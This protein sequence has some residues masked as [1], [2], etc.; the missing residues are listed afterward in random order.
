MEKNMKI[1]IDTDWFEMIQDLAPEK[2]TE[3]L[4]AILNYPNTESETRI[5]KN[6]IKPQLEKGRIAY[7]NKINNLKQ[8]KK[9]PAETGVTK[10]SKEKPNENPDFDNNHIT[11]KPETQQENSKKTDLTPEQIEQNKLRAEKL[12]ATT[13]NMTSPDAD[14]RW[15]ANTERLKWNNAHLRNFVN[16]YNQYTKKRLMEWLT[17]NIPHDRAW[18]AQNFLKLTSKFAAKDYQTELKRYINESV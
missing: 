11:Q 14:V 4:Q 13:C 10:E 16:Q 8:N 3:V 12:I 1:M 15:D 9:T 17:N 7:F 6:V 5:W 18:N 2:Q